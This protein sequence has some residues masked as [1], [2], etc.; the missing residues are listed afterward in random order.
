M[1]EEPLA[2]P[3]KPKKKRKIFR[4]IILFI[5]FYP[6]ISLS[7]LWLIGPPKLEICKETVALDNPPMTADGMVDYLKYL[8]D[9]NSAGVTP[10]NNFMVPC[11]EIFGP[12]DFLNENMAD[13]YL[14]EIGFAAATAKKQS[15]I[16]PKY[17]TATTEECDRLDELIT[18]CRDIYWKASEHP[19]LAGYIQKNETCLKEMNKAME[20]P[21]FYSPMVT[22]DKKHRMLNLMLPAFNS[23]RR[24]ADIFLCRAMLEASNGNFDAAWRDIM[25]VR[26]LGAKLLPRNKDENY[27]LILYLVGMAVVGRADNAAITLLADDRLGQ[28]QL[29]T[30]R[31]EFEQCRIPNVSAVQFIFGERAFLID[32]TMECFRGN[33]LISELMGEKPRPEDYVYQFC[34]RN[35]DPNYVLRRINSAYDMLEQSLGESSEMVLD[36]ELDKKMDEAE[37]QIENEELKPQYIPLLWMPPNVQRRVMGDMAAGRILRLFRPSFRSVK[38]LFAEMYV[39]SRLIDIGMALR[40]YKIKTGAYPKKLSDLMPG[41]FKE[42]PKDPFSGKDYIYKLTKAG[43][44]LYSVGRNFTD[45][46]GLVTERKRDGDIVLEIPLPLKK[47]EK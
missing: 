16:P 32:S 26:R 20:R 28:Q 36:R 44:K 14:K 39:K 45:E 41:Y 17:A 30:F 40:E 29:A 22:G 11:V 1:Q 19:E 8:N 7:L 4:W 18:Q 3:D 34:I 42:L 23:L 31:A 35:A 47:A 9:I 5:I 10:E 38:Y 27:Y 43:F 2:T 33:S 21:C 25:S 46:G 12:D 15:Y 6:L 13:G 37:N 24:V